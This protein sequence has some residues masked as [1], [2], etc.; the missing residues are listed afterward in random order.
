MNICRYNFDINNFGSSSDFGVV[1]F[2]FY[3]SGGKV[4]VLLLME[5]KIV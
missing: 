5:M 1:E 4:V 2:V 3:R